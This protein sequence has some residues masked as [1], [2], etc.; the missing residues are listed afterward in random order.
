MLEFPKKT[1]TPGNDHESDPL[2]TRRSL[3]HS[4]AYG[5]AGIATMPLFDFSLNTDRKSFPAERVDN[6][7][8]KWI[9]ARHIP[10]VAIG[11]MRGGELVYSKGFGRANIEGDISVTPRTSFEIASQTKQFT[12]FGMM[13]LVKDRK[14]SLDDPISKF[15]DVPASWGKITVRHLLTHT[16]G[17]KDYL[18]LPEFAQPDPKKEFTRNEFLDLITKQPLDF[19]PGSRWSYCNSGYFLAGLIIEKCSGKKYDQFLKERI[20]SPLGMHN[21]CLKDDGLN[22]A[23][24]TVGYEWKQ[25]TFTPID[26]YHSS[27]TFSAGGLVST[28][29]DLLK[30]QAA[31]DT[32]RLLPNSLQQQLWQT[33]HLNNGK[34]PDNVTMISPDKMGY[35]L[36]WFVSPKSEKSKTDPT[37]MASY[38]FI[39]GFASY[40]FK[41]PQKDYTIVVLTNKEAVEPNPF[42]APIFL[43]EGITSISIPTLD[44]FGHPPSGK[45]P[46]PARLAVFNKLLVGL[47]LGKLEEQMCTKDF[48]EH[49]EPHAKDYESF[50]AALGAARKVVLCK[51]SKDA[52][53]T[54]SIYKVGFKDATWDFSITLNDQR[55]IVNFQALHASHL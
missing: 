29:E 44:P 26:G 49:F 11:I 4:V 8:E 28:L 47:R 7:V 54:T 30:W 32:N 12:A 51:E 43:A 50:L 23:K 48:R 33:T 53:G 9:A 36:G 55:K 2:I 20:F 15:L 52:H 10:G 46:D 37:W 22:P 21:T 5:F 18:S 24:R 42:F 41:A 14:L 27:A 6:Y 35:G 45:A 19:E 40:V 31:L 34:Q 39:Q 38:G 13:L 3:L 17:I 1:A 16:S 25:G